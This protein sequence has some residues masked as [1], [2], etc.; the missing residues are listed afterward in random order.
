MI[1]EDQLDRGPGRIVGIEE[2]KEFYE[3]SAAVPDVYATF[4]R[5][6]E[7]KR[8]GTLSLLAG[9]DL[10]AGKVHALV[11]VRQLDR[12]M[13]GAKSLSHRKERRGFAVGKLH[14]GPRHPACRFGPRPQEPSTFQSLRRSSP[15]RA[16]AAIL[17]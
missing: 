4:A 8:H 11:K 1:I 12:L 14:R 6:H 17:P 7:C 9:I 2:L 15:T 13:M 3:L 5:D 10:L 16:L